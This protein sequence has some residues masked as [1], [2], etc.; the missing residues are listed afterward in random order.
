MCDYFTGS[1]N[2]C[3]YSSDHITIESSAI[4]RIC[5]L[6]YNILCRSGQQSICLRLR[7]WH[8]SRCILPLHMRQCAHPS[9]PLLC[10]VTFPQSCLIAY[11][12]LIL[13][14][15][16]T[17]L[18]HIQTCT[19]RTYIQ[20]RDNHIVCT[21]PRIRHTSGSIPAPLPALPVRLSFRHTL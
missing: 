18:G 10:P 8:P 17:P 12:F 3:G 14:R 9:K 15:A 20:T 2:P 7:V 19:V 13:H 6:S 1:W 4:P 5:P 11:R 21:F 16:D